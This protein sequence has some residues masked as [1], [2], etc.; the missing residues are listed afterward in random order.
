MFLRLHPWS[1]QHFAKFAPQPTDTARHCFLSRGGD[2]LGDTN[3]VLGTALVVAG[4]NIARKS[5]TL[6]E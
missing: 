4:T 1:S 6:V 5:F 2:D 3:A